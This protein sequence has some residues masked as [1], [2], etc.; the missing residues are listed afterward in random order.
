MRLGEQLRPEPQDPGIAETDYPLQLLSIPRDESHP[1]PH[2]AVHLD[3]EGYNDR[4]LNEDIVPRDRFE[5]GIAVHVG[6][7]EHLRAQGILGYD[8]AALTDGV[9]DVP[10][11]VCRRG[12]AGE[13]EE[14]RE[15]EV[16]EIGTSD[17]GK[18]VP[19]RQDPCHQ[20]SARGLG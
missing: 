9:D 19:F 18:T 5:F 11:I 16:M 13:G 6:P 15:R 4:L 17:C 3:L 12:D 10:G 2:A 1:L 14:Q 7:Q 8:Q 20:A